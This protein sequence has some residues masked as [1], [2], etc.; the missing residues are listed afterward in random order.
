M[1]FFVE[2]FHLFSHVIPTILDFLQNALHF[3]CT[4]VRKSVSKIEVN[5]IQ[6][7]CNFLAYF[8]YYM[9]KAIITRMTQAE[10]RLSFR[11]FHICGWKQQC[12]IWFIYA[13]LC[14]RISS[15]AVFRD[16]SQ[17]IQRIMLLKLLPQVW[18]LAYDQNPTISQILSWA[19]C[20]HVGTAHSF[21]TLD[22]YLP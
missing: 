21:D 6:N 15:W 12:S 14:H 10:R 3:F 5:H 20:P 1:V 17:K 18:P 9:S 4:N 11:L 22:W 2:T 16:N 8:S 7:F 19:Y 13:P